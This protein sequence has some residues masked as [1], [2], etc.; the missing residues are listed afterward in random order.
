MTAISFNPSFVGRGVVGLIF[1]LGGAAKIL[2]RD[3][4][5][6]A[7]RA[8]KLVKNPVGVSTVSLCVVCGE[9]MLGVGL[10]VGPFSRA[11]AV[12]ALGLL[13]VFNVAVAAALL[14][15]QGP[16]SCG[17]MILKREIPLGWNVCLRNLG[18]ACL[19]VPSAIPTPSMPTLLCGVAL[20]AASFAVTDVGR[21]RRSRRLII[22]PPVATSPR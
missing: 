4:F 22:S 1:L 7:V 15:S 20:L 18:L 8:Y 13:A 2:S 19:V 5:F 9:I 14:R 12:G 11:A 10:Y 17:C 21:I 6:A 3:E 16:A